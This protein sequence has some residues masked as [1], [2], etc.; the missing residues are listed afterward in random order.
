MI[1]EAE[2]NGPD[3]SGCIMVTL[4]GSEIASLCYSDHGD[5]ANVLTVLLEPRAGGELGGKLLEAEKQI[6]AEADPS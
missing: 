4:D 5:G 3:L 1:V 2:R 6:Q